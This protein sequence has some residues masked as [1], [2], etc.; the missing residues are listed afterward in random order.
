[1]TTEI[2]ATTGI[3]EARVSL[4]VF[5]IELEPAPYEPR[6]KV[7]GFEL[8]LDILRGIRFHEDTPVTHAARLAAELG[9]RLVWDQRE[10]LVRM[11][12]M[13]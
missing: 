13:S 5:H 10:G 9:C 4:P 6:H 12:V 7:P 8:P 11:E 3:S 1:M 2:N